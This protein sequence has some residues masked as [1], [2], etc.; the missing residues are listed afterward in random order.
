[1][2]K[3]EQPKIRR[4]ANGSIDTDSYVDRGADVRARAAQAL[5]RAAVSRLGRIWWPAARDRGLRNG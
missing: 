4:R 2:D 3:V 1:M 5:I